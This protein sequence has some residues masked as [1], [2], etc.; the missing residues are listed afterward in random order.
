MTSTSRTQTTGHP[1]SLQADTGQPVSNSQERT[2]M[3]DQHG[4]APA[5]ATPSVI[6]SP[7]AR[8]NYNGVRV[9]IDHERSCALVDV[10]RVPSWDLVGGLM[11]TIAN[12][13]FGVARIEVTGENSSAVGY[14]VSELPKAL[15]HADEWLS[16]S[17]D[18][19]AG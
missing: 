15:E 7:L 1:A 13:V 17:F 8:R 11:R 10:G 6:V 12:A 3:S 16:S 9:E 2:Q 4:M 19:R 5:P 18:R 14:L